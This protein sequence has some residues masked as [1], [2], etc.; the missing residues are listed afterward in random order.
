[1]AVPK[2]RTSHTRR[3]NRR[4]HNAIGKPNLRA[5]SNCGAYGIPHR[6]CT[7][8]GYYGGKQVLIPRVKKAKA[9]KE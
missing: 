5:C 9:D 3:R 1:M 2:R 6:I 7:A 4:A 8:C